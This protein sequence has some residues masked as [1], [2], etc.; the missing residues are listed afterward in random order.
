M[1]CISDLIFGLELVRDKFGE[2]THLYAEHDIL[3]IHP[4]KDAFSDEEQ[5]GLKDRGWRYSKVNGWFIYT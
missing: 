2:G 3:C 4:D 5:V 1:K